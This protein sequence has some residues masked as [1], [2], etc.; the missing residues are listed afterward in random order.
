MPKAEAEPEA[1]GAAAHPVVVADGS[2]E[3]RAE[4]APPAV[5]AP[6]ELP[7]ALGL[8]LD[9]L[10]K[11]GK[12]AL[13]D[14]IVQRINQASEKVK[15]A[16]TGHVLVGKLDV[17][18]PASSR[19]V[20]AQTD[21][22]DE[23]Y[24]V[25]AVATPHVPVAFWH[26]GCHRVEVIP[27]GPGRGTV[28]Y[29]PTV[30]M[31]ALKQSGGSIVG[32]LL[33]QDV[34]VPPDYRIWAVPVLD[35]V[36]Q[37]RTS[38]DQ[39]ARLVLRLNEKVRPR[40]EVDPKSGRFRISDLPAGR[41][42]LGFPPL[43]LDVLGLKGQ[44]RFLAPA[45]LWVAPG[46]TLDLG[47]LTGFPPPFTREQLAELT[48]K[49]KRIKSGARLRGSVVTED[50]ITPRV[51]DEYYPMKRA[52]MLT[53]DSVTLSSNLPVWP[54]ETLE[55]YSRQ[56]RV[57]SSVG[58]TTT[59]RLP[60]YV[61]SG[62]PV[63]LR[64]DAT[65]DLPRVPAGLF[66]VHATVLEP[67]PVRPGPN[68]KSVGKD[69]TVSYPV[70]TRGGE[71]LKLA[72]LVLEYERT[73]SLDHYWADNPQFRNARH[74]RTLVRMPARLDPRGVVVS[75][76]PTDAGEAGLKSPSI[77]IGKLVPRFACIS[78]AD[79]ASLTPVGRGTLTAAQLPD[80]SGLWHY[81]DTQTLRT[82]RLD[83]DGDPVEIPPDEAKSSMPVNN[84]ILTLQEGVVYLA[85]KDA[86]K[87]Y[88]L[89]TATVTVAH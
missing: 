46:Q 79:G 11:L 50:G 51:P 14:E 21:V 38:V 82:M 33:L 61:S 80:G 63:I 6:A 23:G 48:E 3:V 59:V 35:V 64:P 34:S 31:T 47:C 24:F 88:L 2:A 7:R 45:S 36:N 32:R 9:E 42:A 86:E 37:V 84:E 1:A 68:A 67:G 12:K 22:L 76:F 39:R 62:L 16:A 89:F 8:A 13:A 81:H 43:E 53:L 15:S 60:R 25:D 54:M 85:R 49:S 72:P 78:G 30:R 56:K 28:E 75:R 26:A 29:V 57:R 5:V 83:E 69:S 70:I 17:E 58:G 44:F 27:R 4:P 77:S 19:D 18:P 73:V 71:E 10:R 41:W 65:F 87:S 55:W 74:G 40:V 20:I 66:Q 52:G